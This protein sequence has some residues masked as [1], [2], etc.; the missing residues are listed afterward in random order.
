MKTLGVGVIGFGFIGKVHTYCHLN[1]PLFYDP[2]PVRTRLVGVATS[3]TETAQK[4]VEQAGFQFGTTD[5]RELCQCDDIDIIH[6]CTPNDQH[7]EQLLTSMEAGKHIYCDKPLVVHPHEITAVEN[8]LSGWKGKGQVT[9][10][11]RFSPPALRAKQ[12]IEQGFV[13]DVT[14]LKADY[15]HSG[16]VDPHR[17]MGWKQL[18]SAGGGVLQDLGSHLLDLVDWLTGP[19][20]ECLTVNRVLYPTRPGPDGAPTPVEAEDQSVMLVR[21]ADGG[22]GTLEV[23]K[24]ATG[25]EDELR[26]EICGTRGAVRFNSMDPNYLEAYSLDAPERPLGGTRGWN[27]IATVQRYEPPAGFP[28]PKFSFGWT[29]MHMHCLYT[30]LDAIAQDRQPD[31]DIRRGLHL[32]RMLAAAAESAQNGA[33]VRMPDPHATEE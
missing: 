5:W 31:P 26:I 25:A 10:Q 13:G 4:A 19:V 11:N 20:V 17:K 28:G 6:I 21:L 18:K 7:C 30:F 24:I 8:A 3:R 22:L 1:I 23:T 27:R 32:Q 9:L 16:S 29:R 12:L 14:S 2:A 33:W 15:L